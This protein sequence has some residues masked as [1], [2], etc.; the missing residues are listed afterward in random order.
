MVKIWRRERTDWINIR[1][2]VS[3]KPLSNDE[4]C[5]LMMF[6]IRAGGEVPLHSHPQ[7]QYGIVV[8]GRGFFITRQ[9]KI[10]VSEGDSYLIL[11][12][13]E[14]GFQAIEDAMVI[15]IFVPPRT[16]YIPLTRKPDLE[17]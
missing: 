8:S 5:L 4:N 17:A 15:D 11:S 6:N 9:G 2:K 13:E 12:N 3:T 16:D 7:S 1:E 14:H 10:E